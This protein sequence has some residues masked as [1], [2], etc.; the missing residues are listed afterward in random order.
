MTR[1]GIRCRRLSRRALFAVWV[2][3]IVPLA[4]P[5]SKSFLTLRRIIF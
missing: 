2:W 3:G 1:R 5:E 4:K